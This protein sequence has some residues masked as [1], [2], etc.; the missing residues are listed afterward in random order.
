[1]TA[2]EHLD[3][4]G[5]G[6]LE[7][8]TAPFTSGGWSGGPLFTYIEGGP[9][10]VGICEGTETEFSMWDWFTKDHSVFVGGPL[11]L[12]LVGYGWSNWT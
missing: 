6:G 1:M 8:E 4:G 9:R 2:V 12:D 5:H 10:V 3:G 7:L 11:L